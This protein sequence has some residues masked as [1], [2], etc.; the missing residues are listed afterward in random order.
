MKKILET[1]IKEKG[2][3][4]FERRNIYNGESQYI[5]RSRS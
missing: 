3:K 4:L 2:E 5:W 1:E